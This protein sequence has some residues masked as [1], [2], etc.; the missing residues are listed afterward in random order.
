LGRGRSAPVLYP[1]EEFTAYIA[2][3]I[4][5]EEKQA[6]SRVRSGDAIADGAP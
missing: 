3:P 5:Y 4:G 2:D 1:K 6:R